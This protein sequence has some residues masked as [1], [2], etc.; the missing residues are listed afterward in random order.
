MSILHLVKNDQIYNLVNSY[1][2]K[3]FKTDFILFLERGEGKEKGKVRNINVWLP[4]SC[5][6]LGTWLTT[7]SCALTGN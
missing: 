3:L 5:P 2:M 4:P 1:G 6:L 7:K